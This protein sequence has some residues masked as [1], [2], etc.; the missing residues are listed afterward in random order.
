M[1][2]L[3]KWREQKRKEGRSKILS[4]LQDV[5]W[6][7]YQDLIKETGL[8]KST[9]SKYLKEF[10]E[11]EVI[12]KKAEIE[13]WPPQIYY[14]LASL[15]GIPWFDE[16]LE[17]MKNGFK[18]MEE[19][20]S[21]IV[22]TI[23]ETQVMER[24]PIAILFSLWIAQ[25]LR[26]RTLFFKFQDVTPK[27]TVIL[28]YLVDTSEYLIEKSIKIMESFWFELLKELIQKGKVKKGLIWKE[29]SER[30]DKIDKNFDENWLLFAS[31]L[32]NGIKEVMG[33]KEILRSL[34]FGDLSRA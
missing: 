14:K 17:I 7:R 11:K 25:I 5:Q 10:L 22:P 19:I 24:L 20:R 13:E 6:H 3:E 27:Q 15:E 33:S 2:S 1:D 26:V 16:Q 28:E 8:A 34:F 31:I 23:D 21:Q 18:K 29:A 4:V 12:I 30:L 32:N 9:L